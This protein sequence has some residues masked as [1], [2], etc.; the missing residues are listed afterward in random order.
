MNGSCCRLDHLVAIRWSGSNVLDFIRKFPY[1]VYYRFEK[2]FN[3]AL[4]GKLQYLLLEIETVLHSKQWI[5]FAASECTVFPLITVVN[6]LNH[7]DVRVTNLSYSS[8]LYSYLCYS[9]ISCSLYSAECAL[10]CRVIT[11]QCNTLPISLLL[12]QLWS[13]KSVAH[14][15][16]EESKIA[17]GCKKNGHALFL[18][19]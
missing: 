3:K 11:Q 16:L 15:A 19:V 13:F 2:K 5:Y 12:F 8:F 7:A 10:I 9:G 4:Q 18:C 17:I 14:I 1:T 6:L